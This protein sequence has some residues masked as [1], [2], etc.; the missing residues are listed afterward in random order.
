ME[1]S[2]VQIVLKLPILKEHEKCFQAMLFQMLLLT[3]DQLYFKDNEAQIL[4]GTVTP[5]CLADMRVEL[6]CLLSMDVYRLPQFVVRS[7]RQ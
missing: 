1:D 2:T 6:R 7:L 5:E 3:S 4:K